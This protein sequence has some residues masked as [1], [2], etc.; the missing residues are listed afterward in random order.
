[1]QPRIGPNKLRLWF[2]HASRDLGSCLSLLCA[3][4][5]ARMSRRST[6]GISKRRRSAPA[7]VRG[8]CLLLRRQPGCQGRGPRT[9]SASWQ[10]KG[11]E[12]QTLACSSSCERFIVPRVALGKVKK[13]GTLLKVPDGDTLLRLKRLQDFCHSRDARRGCAEQ[14]TGSAARATRQR[15]RAL[16]VRECDRPAE[17]LCRP[18]FSLGFPMF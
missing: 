1:M 5:A 11:N 7:G 17:R 18:S 2:G 8:P 6:G 4:P 12:L 9:S 14:R 13:K 16:D 15:A 10:W 3:P